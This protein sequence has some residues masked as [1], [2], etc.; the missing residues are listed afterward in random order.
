MAPPSPL[1][2][3]SLVAPPSLAPSQNPTNVSGWAESATGRLSLTGADANAKLA[4]LMSAA[5]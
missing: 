1:A 3:P 4:V 5:Q 2:P